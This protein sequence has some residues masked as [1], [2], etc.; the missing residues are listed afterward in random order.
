MATPRPANPAVLDAALGEGYTQFQ[1]RIIASRMDEAIIARAGGVRAAVAPTLAQLD[2]PSLLP[3]IE[4]ALD[5]LVRAIDAGENI[6]LCLDHDA[7]GVTA[8]SVL[9]EGLIHYCGV[10]PARVRA[11]TTDKLTEGYGVSDAYVERLLTLRPRPSLL[12]TADQGS[13]DEPRIARLREVGIDTIVTD[14]HGMR[15]EGP[16]R[17]AVA[18]INPIRED[19]RFPDPAV[20]GCHVAWLLVAALRARMVSQGRTLPERSLAQLLDLVGLGTVCDCVSLARSINNR[21]IIRAALRRINAPTRR[22]AWDAL[23]RAAGRDPAE[24]VT[25]A[26]LGWVYGPRTNASGRVASAMPGIAL[27]RAGTLEEAM[28]FAQQLEQS[29]AQRRDLQAVMLRDARDLAQALHERGDPV[30]VV[31]LPDGHVGVQGIVAAHLA[32]EYRAPAICLAPSPR[33]EAILS[34]SMRSPP[35]VHAKRLLDEVAAACPGLLLSHGGHAGAA[36]LRIA[37]ADYDAL[38]AAINRAPGLAAS[39]AQADR[40][41]LV[42]AAPSQFASLAVLD[43][44]EALGPYGMDF[45]QPLFEGRFAVSHVAPMGDGS[46]LRMQLT[47]LEGAGALAPARAVWFGA[48]ERAQDIPLRAHVLYQLVRNHWRGRQ[49]VDVH[50]QG[51]RPEGT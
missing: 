29:N 2:A 50:V 14:H 39:A 46:H 36:G 7:D 37:A 42:D 27:L 18:T 5:R 35:P 15:P 32:R 49:S 43:E 24:P 47:P 8:G 3:D 10:D 38:V 30:L 12:I 28:P 19:G 31:W 20:A 45:P 17:S 21:A 13:C 16:P 9:M 26:T 4:P 6:V 11:C 41:E 44:I 22:P 51:L 1:A 23:A 25:E 40:G 48:G 34:G 33:D